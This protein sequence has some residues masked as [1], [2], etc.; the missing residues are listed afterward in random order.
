MVNLERGN[1][2]E[3]W[4]YLK[5]CEKA[6]LEIFGPDHEETSSNYNNLGLCCINLGKYDEALRY[7]QL[8]EQIIQQDPTATP[9]EKME[10]V[11][12]AVLVV[13][14]A[15]WVLGDCVAAVQCCEEALSYF[16]TAEAEWYLCAW[17]V[18]SHCNQA[19]FK[20][21]NIVTAPIFC[22]ADYI[23]RIWK[24]R[25]PKFRTTKQRSS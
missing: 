17:L 23:G 18:I 8:A 20:E 11:A 19:L 1:F 7:L 16:E 5:T 21:T 15:R 12:G 24:S 14:I 3:A 4:E 22:M 25:K 9:E 10:N 2:Q 6:I 13:G